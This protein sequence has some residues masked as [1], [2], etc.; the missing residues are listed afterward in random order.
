MGTR[1]IKIYRQ[2]L[3]QGV[4]TPG[5]G[6]SNSLILK[7]FGQSCAFIRG[8][9]NPLEREQV[10][11]HLQSGTSLFVCCEAPSGIPVLQ[12][13]ILSVCIARVHA[14]V[15]APFGLVPRS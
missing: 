12:P 3:A 14:V 13:S 2:V 11:T 1:I 15:A 10:V 7:R 8:G 6:A 5:L 4:E 9:I